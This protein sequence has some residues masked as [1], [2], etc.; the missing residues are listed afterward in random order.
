MELMVIR[1]QDNIMKLTE[2]KRQTAGDLTG[3]KE[4]TPYS[5]G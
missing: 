4:M 5:E 3:F 1:Y 2:E